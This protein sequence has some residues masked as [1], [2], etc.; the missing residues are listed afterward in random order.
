MAQKPKVGLKRCWIITIKSNYINQ[1]QKQIN[2]IYKPNNAL[3]SVIG[4]IINPY[5]RKEK[6]EKSIFSFFN[7]ESHIIPASAPKGDKYAAILLPIMEAYT[8]FKLIEALDLIISLN[9]TLIGMLLIIFALKK[10]NVPYLMMLKSF[11]NK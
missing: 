5:L 9:K 3:I 4:A 1:N 6:K 11:P 7:M 10:D 2:D 8:A